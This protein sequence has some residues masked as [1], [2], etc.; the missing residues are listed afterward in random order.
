MFP[1][2]QRAHLFP[3]LLSKQASGIPGWGPV[4]GALSSQ[5][6]LFVCIS[7]EEGAGLVSRL[8]Q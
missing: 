5:H 7:A 6:L 1:S 4:G 2:C 3:S 8:G